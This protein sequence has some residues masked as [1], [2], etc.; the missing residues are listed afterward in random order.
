MAISITNFNSL[1]ETALDFYIKSDPVEQNTQ[2]KPLLDA[3][4]ANKKEFPG[5]QGYVSGPVQGQYA[6]DQAGFFGW[7]SN[8]DQVTFVHPDNIQRA[9]YLWREWHAGIVLDF[10]ELKQHGVVVD[11]SGNPVKSSP[12]EI[13]IVKDWLQSVVEGD[14]G[15]SIARSLQDA[16][17]RDGSQADKA[18][19]GLLGLLD[20]DPTSGIV[21]NLNRATYSWWRHRVDLSIPWSPAN[22]TLTKTLRRNIRQ[23]R[24]YGG[25]PNLI[26]AGSSAIDAL[27]AEIHEKGVYTM[28]GFAKDGKNDIGMSD[29]RVRGVGMVQY[30]PWLDDHGLDK[31][32]MILDM[33]HLRLMPM[34]GAYMTPLK[35]TRPYDQMVMLKSVVGTVAICADMFNCHGRYRVQ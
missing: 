6:A 17:F 35:A 12:Q 11:M 16:Y 30:E 20:E 5:G 14:M 26:L 7:Y 3:L 25:K 1:A 10:T 29:I 19:I 21:G 24:R 4:H 32:I 13:Q 28:E 15:E 18:V 34:K 22:Q 23:Q 33:N 27:E 2:D 9:K 31:E 8:T